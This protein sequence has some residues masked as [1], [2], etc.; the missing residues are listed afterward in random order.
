MYRVL[1]VLKRRPVDW[2]GCVAHSRIDFEKYYNH[3][4]TTKSGKGGNTIP[5]ATVQNGEKSVSFR[6]WGRPFDF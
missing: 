4:V 2:A 5:E 3:K 1:K 6:H